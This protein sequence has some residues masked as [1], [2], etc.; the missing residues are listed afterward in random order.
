MNEPG[1]TTIATPVDPLVTPAAAAEITKKQFQLGG[2][3]LIEGVMMRSPHFVAA[4]VRRADGSI[5][6]RV[7]P[8]HSVMQR[9]PML[10]WPMVRGIVGL[11]EM[12]ELGMRYLNWSGNVAMEDAGREDAMGQPGAASLEA[13]A[14]AD[15]LSAGLEMP[16]HPNGS[17][18]PAPDASIEPK[19]M[20]WW[21]FVLTAGLS[22][23]MGLL[24]FVA[25][26]N[27]L[28]GW[29]LQSHTHS[30]ILLNL[31]EGIIK[32]AIFVS[33]LWLIGRRPAIQR[34]FEYHGA[35]HKV[36]YA[37]ENGRPLT[38]EGARPFD[39][40]HPRCGTG[41]ALLV[42]LV[43]MICF[44]LL[45]WSANPLKRVL[46]RFALMPLVAGIS[47]EIIKL[48]T[49][50]RWSRVAVF[51]LTPGLWLQRLTTRQPDDEQLEVS[52][53]AMRAVIAAEMNF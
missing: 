24:L 42:V 18:P 30:K 23:G 16:N 1:A 38:P 51:I 8:V 52:C 15:P 5:A 50:P 35:E 2:Q 19:S 13:L 34:V 36:V 3:A 25:L 41:F 40:P 11:I 33:Y 6:T 45:P 7:E 9:H 26:P 14:V 29:L 20:P 44:V 37:A 49:N 39:T 21:S 17:A 31:V 10:G 53:T 27:V 22:F 43:S 47:Y 32:L 4:A 12:L 28:A 48:T 46:L